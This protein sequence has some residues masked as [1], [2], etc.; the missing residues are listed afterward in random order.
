MLSL[1]QSL[2][3]PGPEGTIARSLGRQPE[4]SGQPFHQAVKRRPQ[5]SVC[6]QRQDET[7][8]TQL[9]CVLIK[10]LNRDVNGS[11]RA[12]VVK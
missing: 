2:F 9:F 3:C 7:Q 8:L 6:R 5:L 1:L 10:E 12:A 11:Q 4:D